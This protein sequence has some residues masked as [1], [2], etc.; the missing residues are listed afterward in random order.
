MI[1]NGRMS[2]RV[3][4]T[5]R[6]PVLVALLMVVVSAVVTQQVLSRLAETQRANLAALAGAYLDGLSAAVTVPVL[7]DDI[8]EVF[9]QL[10][11]A[12]DKYSGVRPISTIVATADDRVVAA[13]E[14][15]RFPTQSPLAAQLREIMP[16]QD[17]VAVDRVSER[18]FAA[19]RLDY[20]GRT[21]GRIYAELD[22]AHLLIERR[23]VLLT[24]VSTNALLTFL[25]AGLGYL[26]VRGMIRPIEV[27]AERFEQGS[28]GNMVP[29][30]DALAGQNPEAIGRLYR[31]YNDMIR[32]LNDREALSVRLAEEEKLASLGRLASGL[33]HEINNPLGGLLNAVDT[34]ERH[35]DNFEV[36]RTG[37][38][39]LKR[40]LKG[41]ENV[42]RST[43]V[44]YKSPDDPSPLAPQDIDDL[45]HLISHEVRRRSLRLDWRN[46]LAGPIGTS[47]GQVRQALL[48]LLLNAC[49]ASPVGGRLCLD[50]S[51]QGKD[52]I[53]EIDDQGSG[54]GPEF[55]A[56]LEASAPPVA[57]HGAG[58]GLWIVRRLIDGL[59]GLA[60]I[61]SGESGTRIRLC[62]PTAGYGET[63][64]VA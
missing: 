30:P 26:A 23:N 15:K 54:I 37:I 32:A 16:K 4:L 21:I 44:T 56:I 31:Q 40:G 35:G 59:N 20:N 45:R 13:S 2:R 43:L 14:P 33:A 36:R 47:A 50:V 48:N 62:I 61:R 19:R 17:G 41:M 9:D 52:L 27:L 11:R 6:V 55:K 53:I 5:V 39:L 46:R 38:D 34:L 3:P 18:A 63:E 42:L 12:R 1:W 57:P 28:A 29:I 49:A 64:H 51:L 10:D 58:L 60:E 22:I 8:W 25:L 24:L 7:R